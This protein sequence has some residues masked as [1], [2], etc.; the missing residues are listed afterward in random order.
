MAKPNHGFRSTGNDRLRTHLIFSSQSEHH[1][2][3]RKRPNRS[4]EYLLHSLFLLKFFEGRL[5]QA[6]HRKD[7]MVQ[8]GL[9]DLEPTQWSGNQRMMHF[10][11]MANRDPFF[12]YYPKGWDILYP[13]HFGFFP[14]R[15]TVAKALYIHA[16][17]AFTDIIWRV[18]FWEFIRR[19]GASS[20]DNIVWC[21]N[22]RKFRGSSPAICIAAFGTFF[23]FGGALMLYLVYFNA[24][25]L[26]PFPIAADTVPFPILVA[27][28]A[29]LILGILFLLSAII[30]SVSSF[31]V[32]C[33][34]LFVNLRFI[35]IEPKAVYEESPYQPL[36]PP[37]YPVLENKY[38][39]SSVYNPQSELKLYPPV[40]PGC[41]TLSLHSQNTFVANPYNTLR[42]VSMNRSD[43]T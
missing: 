10:G 41:S 39:K 21:F 1:V 7:E 26:W 20:Y 42:A 13:A 19:I 23:I 37:A 33:R 11:P 24:G 27:G 2:A 29:L 8:T 17:L 36:P 16:F 18:K 28:P 5:Q 22:F 4:K 15:A 3:K 9:S 25:A 35:V 14:Y 40:L 34:E 6:L 31:K 43:L 32:C 12:Y 30:C 38:A